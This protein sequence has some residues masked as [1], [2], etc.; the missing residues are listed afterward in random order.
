M[1]GP[2]VLDIILLGGEP[3][4]TGATAGVLLW[5]EQ[6]QEFIGQVDPTQVTQQLGLEL[7]ADRVR[8]GADAALHQGE[9]GGHIGVLVM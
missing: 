7:E 6:N 9:R 8:P 5:G 1:E 2:G 3:L 4:T